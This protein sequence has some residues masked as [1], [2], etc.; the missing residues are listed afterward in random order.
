ML[1]HCRFDEACDSSR[2]FFP[3]FQHSGQEQKV[4][5][6]YE[7][8]MLT[9]PHKPEGS[10]AR[11]GTFMSHSFGARQRSETDHPGFRT[12]FRGTLV[13]RRR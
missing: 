7:S 9:C 8:I 5:I 13:P 3:I 1:G 10:A 11:M 6:G 2:E 12:A 4:C